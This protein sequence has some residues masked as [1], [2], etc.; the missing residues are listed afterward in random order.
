MD[1]WGPNA[2]ED[3]QGALFIG[4]RMFFN[5][6]T[7][8]TLNF[9]SNTRAFTGLAVDTRLYTASCGPCFGTR[10]RGEGPQ[11]HP[12]QGLMY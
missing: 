4:T 7:N 11:N 8:Y 3:D 1:L 10:Y 6:S 9:G 5:V 2:S 12:H